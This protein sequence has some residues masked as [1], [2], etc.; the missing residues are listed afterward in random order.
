MVSEAMP[1]RRI[2]ASLEA[3]V[4]AL[5]ARTG[6][7]GLGQVRIDRRPN[8]YQSTSPSEV[9]TVWVADT[10][11]TRFLSKTISAR[12][13]GSIRWRWGPDYE[14]GVYQEVLLPT[15]VAV[16]DF[17]GIFS[18]ERGMRHL[19]VR[20]IEGALPVSKASPAG[21]AMG[22]AATWLGRF[23]AQLAVERLTAIQKA[24]LKAHD[25]AYYEMWFRRARPFLE[26]ASTHHPNLIEL[27]RNAEPV[28]RLLID[29]PHAVVHGD[30]SPSNVLMGPEGVSVVDWESAAIG[31]CVIDLA[32][33]IEGW[34]AD[35]TERCVNLYT[36]EVAGSGGSG[37][38]RSGIAAGRVYHLLRFANLDADTLA[39]A[40]GQRRAQKLSSA[41]EAALA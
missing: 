23:H 30:F 25:E 33:L 24:V 40:G 6:K 15:G 5:V 19:A 22:P 34:D 12:V 13:G 39:T 10:L 31:P 35:V 29:S 8:R 14:A 16:P 21:S 7:A 9:A 32:S 2:Y 41:L 4:Q 11:L 27:A 36:A 38:L 37:D 1:D 18:D 20:F 28:I 17:Y 26:A 3:L